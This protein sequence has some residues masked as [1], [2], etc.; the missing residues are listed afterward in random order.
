MNKSSLKKFATT[1]RLELLQRVVDRAKIYGID[2]KRS[3]AHTILPS[4]GFQKLGDALL[5]AEECTQRNALIAHIYAH[6]D[7][8][9]M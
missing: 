1:A 2:E 9:T 3:N 8:Q 5:S 6:G 4:N 7:R